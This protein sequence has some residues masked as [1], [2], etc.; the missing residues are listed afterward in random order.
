MKLKQMSRKIVLHLAVLAVLLISGFLL[1][2]PAKTTRKVSACVIQG[3]A[4]TP[5]DGIP[6]CDCTRQT[7]S[8]GCV[9]KGPCGGEGDG[10]SPIEQS[11]TS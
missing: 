7:G 10:P 5:P 11:G 6:V 3:T 8:C 4:A 9:V 1:L 2:F